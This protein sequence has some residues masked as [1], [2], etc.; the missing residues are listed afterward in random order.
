MH[1][2]NS[3]LFTVVKALLL[4]PLPFPESERLVEVSLREQRI[5]LSHL[6]GARLLESTRSFAATMFAVRSGEARGFRVTPELI[7]LL[8]VRPALSRALARSD[9]G[10]KV[11]LI[12]FEYWRSLGSPDIAGMALPLDGGAYSVIGVLPDDFFLGV[13]DAKLIVPDI[14][15]GERTVAR[16]RPGATPAQAE[17][18]GLLHGTRV[19]VTPLA[20]ALQ[21]SDSQPVVLLLATAGSLRN[22]RRIWGRDGA[23]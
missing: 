5:Q 18:A 7:P 17:I 10:A 21:G 1:S 14:R 13:R 19:E 2:G 15:A 20:R 9:G 8:G 12:S 16:P 22:C 23:A 3:T 4:R 11:L 6:E